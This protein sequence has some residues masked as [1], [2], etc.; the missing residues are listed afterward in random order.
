MQ[1][2]SH[3]TV[4]RKN[5]TVQFVPKKQGFPGGEKW[6]IYK[7]C[8][9][10]ISLNKPDCLSR[11]V[12]RLAFCSMKQVRWDAIPSQGYPSAFL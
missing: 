9:Q 12:H 3:T 7:S 1:Q 4:V 6:Y 11:S 10:F 5:F 8:I 2:K